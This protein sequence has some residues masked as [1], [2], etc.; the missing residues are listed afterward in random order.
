MQNCRKLTP[1]DP[2]ATEACHTQRQI[3][4]MRCQTYH[5]RTA[6]KCIQVQV[7]HKQWAI[8]RSMIWYH[9]PGQ[10]TDILTGEVF[11]QKRRDVSLF[12]RS[13]IPMLLMKSCV[14]LCR[15]VCQTLCLVAAAVCRLYTMF[16]SLLLYCCLRVE[17]K[18]PKNAMFVNVFDSML[19][20]I[21][22]FVM[23][24][25]PCEVKSSHI[26]NVHQIWANLQME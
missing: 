23:T 8:M 11:H 6:S 4:K 3:G 2:N 25:L 20:H 15:E 12:N 1:P 16:V 13:A 18:L 22:K 9:S 7:S 21:T 5:Q 26:R 14:L 19:S 24:S 10:H 17:M